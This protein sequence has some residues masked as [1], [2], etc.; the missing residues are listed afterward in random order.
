LAKR[1]KSL[2]VRHIHA[3]WANGPATAAWIVSMLTGIPF[4]FS[5]RAGDICP[6]DGALREKMEAASF[7][8]VAS[9]HNIPYLSRLYPEFADKIHLVRNPS[10]WSECRDA[11]VAMGS[12]LKILALARFVATKGLEYLVRAVKI[13]VDE[14]VDVQ[15]TLGGS[16]ALE[17]PLKCLAMGL[18]IK[19]RVLFP[20]FIPHDRAQEYIL[21]ADVFVMP[22]VVRSNGDRDGLPTVLMEALLHGVPVIS[23]DVGGIREVVEDGATGLIVP[24]RDPKALAQA[25]KRLKDDP[26]KAREMARQGKRRVSDLYDTERNVKELAGLFASHAL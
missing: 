22:S 14:G 12:P 26:E 24:Q 19:D 23:T 15:L 4:S 25:V 2:G 21:D 8:R 18:G 10:S 7:V 9:A 17:A 1:F 5:A 16:G 3:A 11:P 6:P 13:L 20:G